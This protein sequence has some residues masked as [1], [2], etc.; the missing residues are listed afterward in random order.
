MSQGKRPG[1]YQNLT[2]KYPDY[3]KAVNDLGELLHRQG[4]LGAKTAQLIQLAAA[5][6]Q[7]SEGAVH[8]HAR[9]ALEAGAQAEEIR[10]AVILLTNTLGFPTVSAALSWIEDVLDA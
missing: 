8:S 2:E 6:A 4:P 3:L 10:H 1:H 5:A 9:R 7:G